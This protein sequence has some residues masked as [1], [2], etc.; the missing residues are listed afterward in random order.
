MYHE[1][2]A[3]GTALCIISNLEVVYMRRVKFTCKHSL[4]YARGWSTLGFCYLQQ[5]LGTVSM[6]TKDHCV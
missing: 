5:V 6:E 2:N 1:D 4:G 3:L